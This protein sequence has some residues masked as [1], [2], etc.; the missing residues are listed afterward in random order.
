MVRLDEAKQF[1]ER[2]TELRDE[3]TTSAS[4]EGCRTRQFNPIQ[5]ELLAKV[6]QLINEKAELQ[7]K[8]EIMQAKYVRDKLRDERNILQKQTALTE[9]STNT[10]EASTSSS[11]PTA[12]DPAEIERLQA[13]IT[14]YKKQID[15]LNDELDST[16]DKMEGLMQQIFQRTVQ[17]NELKRRLGDTDIEAVTSMDKV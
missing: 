14:A 2:L 10:D 5:A 4:S 11:T 6:D 3:F 15:K 13:R 1:E 7:I 9:A 8:M 16:D 17:M 12:A